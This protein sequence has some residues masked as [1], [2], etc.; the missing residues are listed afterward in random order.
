VVSRRSAQLLLLVGGLLYANW[1]VQLLLPVH[2]SL[3]TSYVS[4]LSALSSPYHQAFRSMDILS[5]A[6]VMAGGAW[7]LCVARRDR[8]AATAFVAIMMFGLSNILDALT[9]L[10]CTLTVGAA[11][12]AST[13]HDVWG[14]VGDPHVYASLG[15][16]AFF[17]VALV[18]VVVAG[19]SAETAILARR[20]AEVLGV[21][22]VGASITAGL[23]TA[24]LNFLGHDMLLGL[25]Q[26]VEVLLM[27]VWVALAPGEILMR[28]RRPTPSDPRREKSD[29]RWP[30]HPHG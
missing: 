14:W 20:W 19:R 8:P 10:P 17:A 7:G 25:A 24:D 27:A 9:P 4:E 11:C 12:N 30:A 23:L 18:A 1:V 2:L 22:A 28:I 15:E 26:R 16:E 13:A 6:T 3:L 29:L 21:A 5:G